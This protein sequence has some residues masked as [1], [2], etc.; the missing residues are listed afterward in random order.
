M[1]QP[2]TFVLIHGSWADSSFWNG[3]A[4][5]LR[6]MGHTVYAPEYPGHG[7][8]PNKAVTHAMIS[9]SLV[10]F[11]TSKIYT[12]S[13]LWDTALAVPW[14]KKWL[15]SLPDRIKRIVFYDAFVLNDG[16]MVADEFPPPAQEAFQQL[17]QS[18]KDDTIMLP[19]PLFRETFVNL[20]GLGL[21]KQMYLNI[22]PEPAKPFYEKLD[23]K[24]FYSLNVPKSYLYFT[25]DNVLP[26]HTGSKV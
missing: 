12:T 15:S 9:K 22:S 21:A 24:K 6:K 26:P 4:V 11:I 8:D 25:E 14:F 2:L 7:S 20:A 3:I 10:D 5:E 18:S 13:F 23:L 16:Q 1:Y 17:R 19:F